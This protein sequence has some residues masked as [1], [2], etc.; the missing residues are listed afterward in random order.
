[1]EFTP[2]VTEP[3]VPMPGHLFYE[4]WGK[5]RSIITGAPPRPRKP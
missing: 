5:L 3:L 2:V 1:M 4:K